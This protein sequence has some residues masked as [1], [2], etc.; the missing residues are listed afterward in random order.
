M[1]DVVVD[2]VVDA[3]DF[4]IVVSAIDAVENVVGAV[5][6]I[7]AIIAVV[8][9]VG[10]VVGAEV[11]TILYNPCTKMLISLSQQARLSIHQI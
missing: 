9:L 2:T 8:V 3:V 11:G 10:I 6:A 1:V 7:G 5:G 4:V